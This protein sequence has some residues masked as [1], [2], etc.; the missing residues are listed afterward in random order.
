MCWINNDALLF[1]HCPECSRSFHLFFYWPFEVPTGGL[2]VVFHSDV[3]CVH[4]TWPYLLMRS[5]CTSL[6]LSYISLSTCS[7][8]RG[9]MYTWH[10]LVWFEIFVFKI[11]FSCHL[12]KLDVIHDMNLHIILHL[13]H[14]YNVFEVFLLH[15]LH[16]LEISNLEL[17]SYIIYRTA[18]LDCF[19]L[20]CILLQ[21]FFFCSYTAMHLF[22]LK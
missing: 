1:S 3:V 20:S 16:S 7:C 17:A 10:V 13:S 4:T 8:F 22:K 9:K 2:I 14:V 6:L 12:L 19:F 15:T 21:T 11:N 18:W 5:F